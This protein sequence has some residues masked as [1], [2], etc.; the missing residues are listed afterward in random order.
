MLDIVNEK[1]FLTR[2]DTAIITLDVTDEA[3]DP[4]S[5]V[6]GDVFT[7]TLKRDYMNNEKLLTKTFDE[8]MEISFS[9]NDT[10]NLNFG[11]YCYDI[12]RINDDLNIVDTFICEGGFEV[13]RGTNK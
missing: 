12:R 5:P 9:S 3:G 10:K 6:E 2:G 13:V 4:Y 8:N 1:I 7:F 11:S